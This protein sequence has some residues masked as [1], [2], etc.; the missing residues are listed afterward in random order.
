MG[1]VSG[2]GVIFRNIPAGTGLDTGKV[3]GITEGNA[4]ASMYVNPYVGRVLD[5]F[6][7]YEKT[8]ANNS[9]LASLENTKLIHWKQQILVV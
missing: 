3:E 2:G 7:F 4:Y 1:S 6:A 8:S 5:G 9:E